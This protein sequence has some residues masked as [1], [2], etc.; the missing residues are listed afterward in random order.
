MVFLIIDKQ[1]AIKNVGLVEKVK[2][3][4]E[5]SSF[6]QGPFFMVCC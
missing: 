3:G 4:G 5:F 2:K 6:V 1:I